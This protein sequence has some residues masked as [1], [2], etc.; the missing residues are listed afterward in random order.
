MLKQNLIN[1]F[2]RGKMT[3]FENEDLLNYYQIARG[4]AT[5]E[6]LMEHPLIRSR[7]IF[8]HVTKHENIESILMNG[9]RTG[10]RNGVFLAR[11]INLVIL[12]GRNYIDGVSCPVFAIDL[13]FVSQ[14]DLINFREYEADD[15]TIL[16]PKNIER[17]RIIALAELPTKKLIPRN[18]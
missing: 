4:G 8:F 5:K 17:E 13:S 16:Y 18:E 3:N 6:Q 10:S 12:Y 9:L 15:L 2:H 14:A 11:D 1:S 7:K